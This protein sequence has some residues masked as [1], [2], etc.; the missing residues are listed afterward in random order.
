MPSTMRK[1]MI[2][3]MLCL[4]LGMAMAVRAAA[5]DAT[6]ARLRDALRTTT[7]QLHRLEAENAALQEKQSGQ[8]VAPAVNEK[9]KSTASNRTIAELQRRLTA[10]EQDAAKAKAAYAEAIAVVE[11]KDAEN[12][13]ASAGIAADKNK[14]AICQAKNEAMAKIAGEI[15]ERYENAGFGDILA[16][17]E[18][19]VGLKRVELQNIAQDTGDKIRESTVK[20]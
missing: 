11:K 1:A 10:A 7:D 17:K 12:A 3:A 4:S 14:M 19:F 5:D 15:L 8:S 16:R 18:P 20:P 9:K 2:A 13:A 6:E